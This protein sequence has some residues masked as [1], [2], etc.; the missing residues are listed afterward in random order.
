MTI[1]VEYRERVRLK[2]LYYFLLKVSLWLQFLN[3][4][5]STLIHSL[6]IYAALHRILINTF[7]MTMLL[8]CLFPLPSQE[9]RGEERK[10]TKVVIFCFMV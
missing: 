6:E 8:S 3:S 5:M 1:E 4:R 10:S 9:K 7:C 2:Y